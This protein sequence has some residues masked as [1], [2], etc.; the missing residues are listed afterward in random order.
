MQVS[1]K[2]NFCQKEEWN[3]WIYVIQ[4]IDKVQSGW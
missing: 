2:P 1:Q 3:P 4:A